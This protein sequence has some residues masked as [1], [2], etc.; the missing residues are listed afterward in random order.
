VGTSTALIL[1]IFNYCILKI[2]EHAATVVCRLFENWV[3][4]WM[5]L[6]WVL[7][8]LFHGF[9]EKVTTSIYCLM[10]SNIDTVIR[11][12]QWDMGYVLHGFTYSCWWIQSFLKTMQRRGCHTGLC[13]RTVSIFVRLYSTLTISLQFWNIRIFTDDTIFGFRL[14]HSPKWC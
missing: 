6:D 14:C 13:V 7:M 9:F 1:N 12:T 11:S 5:N 2:L 4:C 10:T 3:V 8:S